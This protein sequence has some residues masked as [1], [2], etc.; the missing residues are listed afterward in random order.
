MGTLCRMSS[1][2]DRHGWVLFWRK[3][4]RLTRSGVGVLRALAI[5]A[6]EEGDEA[7]RGVIEDIQARIEKG[8]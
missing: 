5:C 8:A 4:L 3:Y 6:S 1:D 7:R 2:S